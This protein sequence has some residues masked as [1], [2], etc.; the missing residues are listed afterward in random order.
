MKTLREY[1]DQLDE[2]SRRG[3]LKGAGATAAGAAL[4]KL[5]P[6][7]AQSASSISRYAAD[8]AVKT[9]L[10]RLHQDTGYD[11]RNFISKN[12]YKYV[13]TMCAV[14]RCPDRELINRVNQLAAEEAGITKLNFV[15]GM[16]TN[17]KDHAEDFVLAY[18]NHLTD[19][20]D[21]S[22]SNTKQP[23]P[24]TSKDQDV[25]SPSVLP[26]TGTELAGP[27]RP[28]FEGK[29]IDAGLV[30]YVYAS[31]SNHESKDAIKAALNNYASK[32]GL[33]N[34]INQRLKQITVDPSKFGPSTG[35]NQYFQQAN[36]LIRN[37]NALTEKVNEAYALE[38]DPVEKVDRLFKNGS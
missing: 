30:L 21:K 17:M 2:I 4:G 9:V 16:L 6:A 36:Q 15:T 35:P 11:L 8:L 18:A 19:E 34:N 10:R 1:I 37:I 25:E 7:Q 20:L 3:F 32:T 33:A 26:K 23:D 24:S 14:G 27:V 28:G 38:E 29:V 31:K 22:L 13:S 12:I 5:P